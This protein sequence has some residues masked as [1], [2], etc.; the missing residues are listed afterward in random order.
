[1]KILVP[2]K[3]VIDPYVKIRVKND[4]SGV[5]QQNVKMTINPFD[6]I[7]V[8]AAIQLKEKAI[9]T[10]VSVA[11]IGPAVSQET[12]RQAL[13]LGADDAI[14]LISDENFEPLNIAK[15]LQYLVQT[16][17][18]ELVLMGKQTIDGDHNQTGQ[19]LAGLL[20]WGQATFASKIEIQNGHAIVTREVDGGLETLSV[21][22]PAV[23]TADLRLN[24]PRYPTLPN[25]MKAK[26]KPLSS[27][28]VADLALSLKSHTTVLKITP[29]PSRAGNVLLVK[30]VDELVE[31]LISEAKVL[32]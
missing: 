31:K 7:A 23:I 15:L 2:I 5:E 19:M 11:T 4:N 29:P 25:I 30:T 16:H 32:P 9:A 21:K 8:E 26:S 3:R 6:E 14:H 13:A 18:F 12:L 10:S 17:Q 1:M 20:D 24:Q 28:N 27:K 22:L